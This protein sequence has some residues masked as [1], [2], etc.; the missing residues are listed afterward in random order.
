MTTDLL[1]IAVPPRWITYPPMAL[2]LLK[3]ILHRAGHTV[4]LSDA[5]IEYYKHSGARDNSD[6]IRK[7]IAMQDSESRTWEDMDGSEFGKWIRKYVDQQL[8]KHKPRVVGLSVFTRVSTLCAYYMARVVREQAPK[9]TKILVGGLG[10][11]VPLQFT[12]ALGALPR[13]SLAQT[14][15]DEKVIDTAILGDGEE[16]LLEFMNTLENE[17][18]LK[19]NRINGYDN[20]PYPDYSDLDLKA[21]TPTNNLT[22]PVTGSKG[23]VRRCTFCD[24]PVKF[25]RYQQ[26]S[27]KDIAE[28]CIHLYETYGAKTMYLTD[29]LTNGSMKS[30]LEFT[31]TLA[32]L[33]AKKNYTD[34]EWTGQYITRPAHQIPHAKDYYP[35]MAAS[36]ARG[37][38]VGAESGS[39][40]V[41][42]HMDKKMKISDLFVELEYFRKYGITMAVNLLPSYPTETREDFELT[43]KMLSDFQPYAADG[44]LEKIAGTARWYSHDTLN[45]WNHISVSGEGWHVKREDSNMWWYRPNPELT[46]QERVFRRLAI[47]KCISELKIPTA[48]DEAYEARVITRWYETAKDNYDKWLSGLQE[49]KDYKSNAQS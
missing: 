37:I 8:T 25:G 16:A 5:N 45:R 30:F 12:E 9:G 29:S 46:L 36:G 14:L 4:A 11:S 2:P 43:I 35:L 22:L 27:G 40:R 31:T 47:S 41:L 39:D 24:I 38:T 1:L 44:T 19:I 20:M 18:P 26:R 21:Y 23:C 33:K 17:D 42:E 6:Y 10:A 28:E 34:L 13:D 3:S 48:Q 32:E 7:T 15:L 49:Y